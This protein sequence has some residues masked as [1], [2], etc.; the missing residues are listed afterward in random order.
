MSEPWWKE[1]K[2]KTKTTF[3]ASFCLLMEGYGIQQIRHQART[4]KRRR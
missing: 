1:E 4:Q 3:T 2:G